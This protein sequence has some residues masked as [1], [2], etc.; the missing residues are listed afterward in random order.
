[1]LWDLQPLQNAPYPVHGEELDVEEPRLLP[2]PV[3]DPS[4]LIIGQI[5]SLPSCPASEALEGLKL[6]E[7]WK[8]V[9]DPT[10]PY[11]ASVGAGSVVT[12]HSTSA[13]AFGKTLSAASLP[14]DL[15]EQ[16]DL[17]GLSLAFH[18]SGSYLAVGTATGQVLLYTLL[19]SSTPQ[20]K[21]VMK[22]ADHPAPI[23]AL[24]FTPHLLLVGSDDRTI[25]VH[26][27]KPILHPSQYSVEAEGDVRMGGT[28]AK[29]SG[30]KGWVLGIAAV[31]GGIFASVAAD[32]SVKF[33]DLG[34]ATKNTPVFNTTE[35]QKV[36]GF[37]FQPTAAQGGGEGGEGEAVGSSMT[38]FVTA[39]EDGRLR[40]YR[41]AGLG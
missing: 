16:K 40:W 20:L 11:F 12:L 29:L 24:S 14:Q 34:G 7:A 41:G 37:A 30:H 19:S 4:S 13:S 26:D 5:D 10:K 21:L 1:M 3:E 35:M 18:P 9:L 38:R 31:E 36:N 6:S 28:V 39:S 23:R 8:T 33:W 22:F 15:R 32:R 27:I 25:S 17:F 2:L